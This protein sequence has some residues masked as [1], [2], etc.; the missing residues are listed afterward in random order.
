MARS[1]Y[2]VGEHIALKI[3]DR[4]VFVSMSMDLKTLVCGHSNENYRVVPFFV[5]AL[6]VVLH[7]KVLT[8][9][10]VDQTLVSD[11]SNKRC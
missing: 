8:F 5:S 2:I 3:S 6:F 9:R 11:H 1:N 4:M 10:S 7:K